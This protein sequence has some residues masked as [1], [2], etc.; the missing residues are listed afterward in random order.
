MD[1]PDHRLFEEDLASADFRSGA[2][3]GRW[4]LPDWD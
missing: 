3:A 4:G 2:A 1:T